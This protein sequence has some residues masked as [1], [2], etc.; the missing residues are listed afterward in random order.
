MRGVG[1]PELLIPAAQSP[2]AFTL[3]PSD[4]RKLQQADL[5]FWVGDT[6]EIPLAQ[7]LETS[8]KQ[9]HS[10]ALLE[11]PGIRQLPARKGGFWG[12]AEHTGE[13]S[14][15]H[16]EYDYDPHIWLSIDNAKTIVDIARDR[17]IRIDPSHAAEYRAN[18]KQMQER[19]DG[20][21][22]TLHKELSVV[23]HAP[24]LVFHDAYHYFERQF[25]LKSMGSIVISPDR[26]P[27]ARRIH[28]VQEKLRR[29][30][31]RCIFSEPQ[32][33]PKLLDTLTQGTR[34]KTG[35]LDPIGAELPAGPDAYFL[36][37][38]HLADNLLSCLG[39]TT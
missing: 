38:R 23:R 3:R 36:L 6:F 32:F 22:E 27:G 16:G 8:G 2:H 21:N 34:V 35:T 18:A 20:L 7:I 15:A 33:T 26:Q 5:I 29:L 10:V 1:E 9:Q 13:I 12:Q 25:D 30:K 19:L 37:M 11:Q 31:A 28:E 39:E 14:H 17:L 24:Y 4:M